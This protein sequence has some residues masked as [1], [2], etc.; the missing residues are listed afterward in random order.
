MKIENLSFSV[1]GG[2][3]RGASYTTPTVRVRFMKVR[4]KQGICVYMYRMSH[5]YKDAMYIRYA[6]AG[7][8]LYFLF[9][10]SAD[11][12]YKMVIPCNSKQSDVR[13]LKIMSNDEVSCFVSDKGY[14]PKLDP[15]CNL[16]YIEI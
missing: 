5:I 15:E 11:K 9:T 14:T 10:S 7:N 12:S 16:Y 13:L 4:N 6:R 3:S 1:K 2:A 8:R